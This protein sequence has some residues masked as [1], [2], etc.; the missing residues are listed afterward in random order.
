[1]CVVCDHAFFQ[2]YDEVYHGDSMIHGVCVL[3]VIM[4]S[5]SCMMK[6]I[7]ATA[8][9]MV[10]VCCMWSCIVSVVWWSLW[11]RLHDTW[12]MC[13]VCE[14]CIVSVVWWSLWWRLHDTWCMCDCV[15]YV[16]VHSI[17]IHFKPGHRCF[18]SNWVIVVSFQTGSS[19]FQ[20]FSRNLSSCTFLV[21]PASWIDSVWWVSS[22]S[23]GSSLSSSGLNLLIFISTVYCRILP[24]WEH[25]ISAKITKTHR[26]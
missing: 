3:Y 5:F 11:W 21:T 26:Q 22:L 14:S 25:S 6:F 20:P 24:F 13:V 16:I 10:Y 2:L 7:M 18:I 9:Y 1:M 8:W 19:L 17:N 15:L 4:H 23:P 12:C